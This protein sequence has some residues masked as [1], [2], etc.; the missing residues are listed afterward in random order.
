MLVSLP[1]KAD[2]SNPELTTSSVSSGTVADIILFNGHLVTV[3]SAFSEAQAVAIAGQKLVAVGSDNDVAS[4]RGEH[5]R[6]IDLRGATVLPGINDSHI[7]LTMWALSRNELDLRDKNIEQIRE[8]LA[9]HVATVA[10][11]E[12]IRGVGWS[13]GSIGRLPT[14]ADIDDLTPH[15]PV[16]FQE[17]GHALWVNSN[18]LVL[19]SLDRDSKEPVGAKFE[20]IPDSG[21]LT[22]VFHESDDLLLPYLKSV[23]AK[24]K[25]EAIEAGIHALNRQGITSL[26]IPGVT[27]EDIGL[28]QTLAQEG[29]LTARIGLHVRAGRSLA[30]AKRAV[31]NYADA[32]KGR[33][34]TDQLLTLRGIKLFMDGAPPG[35]T[36]LM[37]DDY[38]CC[39]GEKGLL[40]Y[41]GDTLDNQVKEINRSIE[42]LHQQGYQM[43]IHADGDRSAHIAINGLIG[44]MEKYPVA[45]ETPK[46]NPLRHYLIHGD[47][48]T[49]E[50]IARMA[51]WHIGLTTQPVITAAAG[52]ML[53]D[54]WGK[55]R[56]ERHMASGLFIDGGVWTS[57]STDAPIVVPD[58]KYNIEYA[59]LREHGASPPR[60]NG[61][62]AYRLTVRQ[63]L[64]AHTNTP[65][66][67]DFQEQE[68]GS[69][70]VG[71]L[72]DLVVIDRDILTIDPHE[73]SDLPPC[74]DRCRA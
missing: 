43:G 71:K 65:A 19:A 60:I 13:E 67:Q 15:N 17:M 63:A 54:L 70:E 12:V 9:A 4:F 41:R 27:A 64:I 73:I 46:A 56:G 69:I 35:R 48:I 53:L 28:Y 1:L 31:S 55:K 42:W 6:M 57:L 21:E 3:D 11:G 66:Y 38:S 24:Q 58:W 39:A 33:G 8:L 14:R 32:L 18:T 47:L 29:K 74:Q 49:N 68:K 2:T 52:D 51:R 5:T 20:R 50:D 7:H 72:A 26:T 45:A 30:D 36:A 22:G 34:T 10:L 44:A 62:A 25:L 23:S 61:P 16:V 59:V 37:F 40:L